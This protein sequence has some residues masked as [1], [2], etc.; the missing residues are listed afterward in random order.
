MTYKDLMGWVDQRPF[1]PFHVVTT[2]GKGFEINSPRMIWPGS[3]SVL[4]GLP[5]PAEPDVRGDHIT[6]SML[7]IVRVEPLSVPAAA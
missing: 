4:I 1:S 3:R 6:V 7:H 2:D 5:D